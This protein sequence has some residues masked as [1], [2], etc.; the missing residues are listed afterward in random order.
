MPFTAL[1]DSAPAFRERLILI[2]DDFLQERFLV[3]IETDF[4][5]G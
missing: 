4:W 3:K 5:L 1:N 2:V